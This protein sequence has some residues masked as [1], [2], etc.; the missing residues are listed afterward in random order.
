M[1][2][3]LDALRS[4]RKLHQMGDLPDMNIEEQVPAAFL[5]QLICASIVPDVNREL[6]Q[7]KTKNNNT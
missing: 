4:S 3:T 1:F 7:K 5:S 2:Q 6:P